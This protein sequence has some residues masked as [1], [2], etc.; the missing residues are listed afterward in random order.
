LRPT[1]FGEKSRRFPSRTRPTVRAGRQAVLKTPALTRPSRADRS[2]GPRQTSAQCPKGVPRVWCVSGVRSPGVKGPPGLPSPN[3]TEFA[4]HCFRARA[5]RP[6][7]VLPV[8]MF[9]SLGERKTGCVSRRSR[10]PHPNF[11]PVATVFRRRFLSSLACTSPNVRDSVRFDSGTAIS[12][13][14]LRARQPPG[15]I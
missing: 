4:A 9:L 8:F 3:G 15:H 11:D 6:G 1:R 14:S 5:L 12:G 13:S 7:P 10:A 2:H